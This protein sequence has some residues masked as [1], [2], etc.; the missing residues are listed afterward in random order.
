[1]YI[2]NYEPIHFIF[3]LDYSLMVA[4]IAVV[5]MRRTNSN[6]LAPHARLNSTIH[7]CICYI[8]AH[9]RYSCHSLTNY[10]YS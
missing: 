8:L 2:T 7:C 9:Y 10:H 4:T 3:I 5:K 6:I 1:M